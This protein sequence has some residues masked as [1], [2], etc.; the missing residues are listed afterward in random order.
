MDN[1]GV[2]IRGKIL[3]GYTFVRDNPEDEKEV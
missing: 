3:H 2:Y 1:R